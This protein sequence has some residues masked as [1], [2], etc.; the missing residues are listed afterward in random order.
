MKGL[1]FKLYV[2]ENSRHFR[3]KY[4]ILR[5]HAVGVIEG[6]YWRHLPLATVRLLGK[7]WFKFLPKLERRED[8]TRIKRRWM[9]DLEEDVRELVCEELRPGI[10]AEWA[11]ARERIA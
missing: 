2:F 10:Y 4:I 11:D 6:I 5:R 3:W 7:R 8:G 9:Y 1:A